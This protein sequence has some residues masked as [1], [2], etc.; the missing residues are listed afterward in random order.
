MALQ[1]ESE[2]PV[3]PPLGCPNRRTDGA[4]YSTLD[5]RRG[6]AIDLEI[7]CRNAS[8]K[9]VVWVAERTLAGFS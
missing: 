3:I 9:G 1:Y 8:V 5:I 4:E 2:P 7:T 6:P